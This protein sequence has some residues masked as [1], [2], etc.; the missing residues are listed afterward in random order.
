MSG[1]VDHGRRHL[2]GGT[3]PIPGSGAAS[4]MWPMS[5][6]LLPRVIDASALDGA[7]NFFSS[8]LD[9]TYWTGYYWNN[10]GNSSTAYIY[11]RLGPQGSTWGINIA[12]E[13]NT[14]CGILQFGW[15][16][17]DEAAPGL[18]YDT[19]GVGEGMIPGSTDRTV[20]TFYNTS[21]FS[22]LDLYGT[23]D[24]NKLW[25]GAYSQFRLMGADGTA[26]SANGSFDTGDN[27]DHFNG[28]SG[29]YCLRL[30]VNS[31]N[32]S[33]SAYR[34]PI[35]FLRLSRFTSEGFPVA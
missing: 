21:A 7:G 2:P 13:R 27:V 5:Y 1:Y 25:T 15:Q 10:G 26:L 22:S 11:V 34:T 30:L 3:D 17:L 16:S 32:A 24:K 20:G 19:G 8:T 4:A 28:G 23:A 18:G 35:T 29:I 9:A 33:S 31:K 14:D 6:D 12:A